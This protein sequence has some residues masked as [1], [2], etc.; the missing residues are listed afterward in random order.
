MKPEIREISEE[1]FVLTIDGKAIA[2]IVNE[3]DGWKLE[4]C[5]G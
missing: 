4:V 5:F 2:N 1:V 3:K